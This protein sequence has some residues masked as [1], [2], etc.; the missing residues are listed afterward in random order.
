MVEFGLWQSEREVDNMIETYKTNAH[1]IRALKAQ[2][3]FK[4]HVLRQDS[5]RSV[6]N[7]IKVKDGKRMNLTV[8][9]LKITVKRLVSNAIT[10]RVNNS[11]AFLLGGG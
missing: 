3:R 7:V 11:R 1:K 6:F 5:E 10:T 9:E 8:E 4:Q 2:L